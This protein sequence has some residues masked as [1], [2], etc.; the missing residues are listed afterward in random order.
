MGIEENKANIRRQVEEC[1]NKGELS[2]V[3]ELISPAF[4]YHTPKGDLKGQD[5]FKEWVNIWRTACP[6]FN[7]T[8]DEMVGEG[9]TV[10]VRLSWTGTFTG[11]FLEYEPTGNKVSMK[12][13][14]FYHFKDGKDLGPIPFANILSLIH[15][16]GI[17]ITN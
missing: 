4:V 6:D 16:M 1:W 10:A 2:S 13:A 8:I 11:K 9:N 3:H 14:W 5:G 17:D 15:Q 7:M 12:E